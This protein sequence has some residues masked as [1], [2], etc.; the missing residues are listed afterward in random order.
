MP[1]EED[2]YEMPQLY[3][4]YE[5]HVELAKV[6]FKNFPDVTDEIADNLDRAEVGAARDH[7]LASFGL[8]P[9]QATLLLKLLPTAPSLTM[10]DQIGTGLYTSTNLLHGGSE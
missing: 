5:M 4:A 8:I 7:F 2:E 10:A 6:L 3:S 1:K 9:Y